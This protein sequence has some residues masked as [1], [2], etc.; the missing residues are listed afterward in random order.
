[1]PDSGHILIIS[2]RLEPGEEAVYS[3]EIARNI[4][5]V[6]YSKDALPRGIAYVRPIILVIPDNKD[7]ENEVLISDYTVSF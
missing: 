7:D 1:M 2:K 3:F 6:K 4:K 5:S